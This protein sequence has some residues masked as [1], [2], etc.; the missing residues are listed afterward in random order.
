MLCSE[1]LQFPKDIIESIDNTYIRKYSSDC[2]NYKKWSTIF[3]Y[4]FYFISF[5][6]FNF[7]SDFWQIVDSS[8]IISITKFTHTKFRYTQISCCAT[9]KLF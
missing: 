3:K 7:V 2:Y 4:L 5:L 8:I 6:L 9:Y 1:M